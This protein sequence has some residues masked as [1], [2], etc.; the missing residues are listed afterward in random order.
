MLRKFVSR[1]PNVTLK[2]DQ[3]TD[4]A[5]TPCSHAE[6]RTVKNPLIG[7]SLEKLRLVDQSVYFA[8]VHSFFIFSSDL[9]LN[10][11]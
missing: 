1:V 2:N 5:R 11:H 3:I 9:W 8:V 10:L 6:A 7:M 4:D